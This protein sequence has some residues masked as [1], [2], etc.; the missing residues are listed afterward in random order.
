MNRYSSPVAFRTALDTRLKQDADSRGIDVQ[1]LRRRVAFERIL[2]RLVVSMPGRWVL[3]GGMALEIR[4][5]ERARATKD[6]DLALRGAEL[7]AESARDELV[8][9]LRADVDGDGFIFRLDDAVPLATDD[10]GRPGWR[11]PIDILL[12]AKLF[13]RVRVD[14]VARA[15]EMAPTEHLRLPG[16]DFARIPEHEVEVI[17]RAQHFAEK[18]HAFTR[19]YAGGRPSSRVK[20]LPDLNLLIED[21]LRPSAELLDTCERLFRE[22]ATHPVP[23]SLPDPPADW[24]R[25]YSRLAAELDTG[26]KTMAEAMEILRAFWA[27]TMAMDS[28]RADA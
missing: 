21:G 25:V 26:A 6:L 1:W 8:T 18:L 19:T 5:G 22:R 16:L 24:D 20:D 13:A 9:G 12:A 14:V 7:D 2:A 15:V 10:A 3:K 27:E 17:D 23:E 28:R 4:L 11:F